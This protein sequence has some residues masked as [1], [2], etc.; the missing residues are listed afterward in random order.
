M[1]RT[2]LHTAGGLSAAT[3]CLLYSSGSGGGILPPAGAAAGHRRAFLLLLP[4]PPP[5]PPLRFRLP[6]SSSSSSRM[7][8]SLQGRQS[9]GDDPMHKPAPDICTYH[10]IRQLRTCPLHA[11]RPAPSAL[12]RGRR[13]LSRADLI[14]SLICASPSRSSNRKPVPSNSGSSPNRRTAL[15]ASRPGPPSGSCPGRPDAEHNYTPCLSSLAW[16]LAEMRS[17]PGGLLLHL[18]PVQALLLVGAHGRLAAVLLVGLHQRLVLRAR[19]L[20]RRRL[21]LRLGRKLLVPFLLCIPNQK[22]DMLP[23]TDVRLL[24]CND[25]WTLLVF[26]L[27]SSSL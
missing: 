23:E 17:T 24:L 26:H 14:W 7:R 11:R 8:S 19:L 15:R 21:L 20:L 25:C 2:R 16:F 5:P 12:S 13:P 4:P 1:L 18:V 27:Y 3:C 10:R 6:S 9:E 22:R